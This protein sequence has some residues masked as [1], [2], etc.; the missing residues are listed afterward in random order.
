EGQVHARERPHRD[1]LPPEGQGGAVHRVPEAM[2]VRGVAPDQE[3]AQ[4]RV[5]HMD[6]RRATP[7]HAA[8][9][10]A[11]VRLHHDCN[12]AHRG[13]PVPWFVRPARDHGP[14]GCDFHGLATYT[15]SGVR[16]SPRPGPAGG[17]TKPW[18]GA[19]VPAGTL[20]HSHWW[21][22]WYSMDSQLPSAPPTSTPP[23]MTPPPHP[24]S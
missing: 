12:R 16:A 2:D 9:G 23:A 20:S 1:A 10:E 11:G 22:M 14:D 18:R 6:P 17:R 19:N 4:D 3:F 13:P 15:S 24:P 8:P 21:S 5:D 7:T